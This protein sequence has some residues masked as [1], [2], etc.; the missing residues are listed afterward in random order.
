MANKLTLAVQPD[1]MTGKIQTRV[2]N[3]FRLKAG[4]HL[5]MENKNAKTIVSKNRSRSANAADSCF[6]TLFIARSGVLSVSR[7]KRN[8]RN[9]IIASKKMNINKKSPLMNSGNVLSSDSSG[10]RCMI[11]VV[12][13][14]S[15]SN[16]WNR[17]DQRVFPKINQVMAK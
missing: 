10:K 4:S 16:G 2:P 17:S 12:V 15:K 8:H 3:W 11:P 5:S 1:N 7:R 6:E 14:A 9:G 13:P